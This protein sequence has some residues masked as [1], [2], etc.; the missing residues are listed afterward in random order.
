MMVAVVSRGDVVLD[1]PVLV[2]GF[3]DDE[4]FGDQFMVVPASAGSSRFN[5]IGFHAAE[6]RRAW[7]G[8]QGADVRQA[9]RLCAVDA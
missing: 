8:S 3:G 4:P 2:E 9:R 7:P 1:A 5:V 6:C